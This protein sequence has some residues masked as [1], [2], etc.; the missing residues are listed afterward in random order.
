MY[1]TIFAYSFAVCVALISQVTRAEIIAEPRSLDDFDRISVSAGIVVNVAIA[2]QFSVVVNAKSKHLE[3]VQTEVAD[4]VLI[5]EGNNKKRNFWQRVFGYFEAVDATVD[6]TMPVLRGV[7]ISG[8]SHVVTGN[9]NT[10]RFEGSVSG[11]GKL[12]L[13][14]LITDDTRLSV[15]GSGKILFDSAETSSFYSSVSGSGDML[16]GEL[17]A[18]NAQCSVTGSGSTRIDQL[19]AIELDAEITGSGV[20]EAA[21][22]VGDAHID[23]TGSGQFSGI[24]LDVGTLVNETTGSGKIVLR[25]AKQV[26]SRDKSRGVSILQLK[27]KPVTLNQQA[28]KKGLDKNFAGES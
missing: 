8:S 23:V 13:A 12:S 24:R 26:S 28:E 19:M 16:L 17:V 18:K 20:I 1:K 9:I 3:N 2:G 15:S 25:S 5:I 21:G 4:G 27:A 14:K 7:R 6:I 10:E 22:T 11:S